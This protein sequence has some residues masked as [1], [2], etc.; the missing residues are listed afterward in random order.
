MRMKKSASL[1]LLA[2]LLLAAVATAR[3][4]RKSRNQPHALLFG[5][6]FDEGGRLVRGARVAVKVK[7]GKGK[8]EAQSDMQGEFAVHLPPGKAVYVVEAQAPGLLP[9]RKEVAFE[10]EERQDVALH[11]KRQ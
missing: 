2:V 9:D 4:G 7:E 6:V 8:W 1:A 5:T 10:G 3:Q 11:L